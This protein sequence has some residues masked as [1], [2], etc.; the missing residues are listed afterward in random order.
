MRWI[1]IGFFLVLIGMIAILIGAL[2]GDAETD[3]FVGGIFGFIPFGFS[4][5][6]QLFYAGMALTAFLFILF[7]LFR[8]NGL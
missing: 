1:E 6:K 5:D 8:S 2:Q 4:N 7:I 3:Y